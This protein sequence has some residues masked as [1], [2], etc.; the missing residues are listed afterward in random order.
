VIVAQPDW[1]DKPSSGLSL[2]AAQPWVIAFPRNQ[3]RQPHAY[4]ILDAAGRL[5][6]HRLAVPAP[7][8]F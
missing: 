5:V 1:L 8:I 6:Q 7:L 4:N 2:D 3:A